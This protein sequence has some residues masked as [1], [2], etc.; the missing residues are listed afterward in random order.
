MLFPTAGLLFG[1]ICFAVG[2]TM[3]SLSRSTEPELGW[4]TSVQSSGR[5]Q[6]KSIFLLSPTVRTLFLFM[7]LV[8]GFYG[9]FNVANVALAEELGDP[10]I[11][12]IILVASAI[13]SMVMGIAFGAVHLRAPQYLQVVVTGVLLGSFYSLLVFADSPLTVFLTSTAGALFYAP[14]FISC[15]AACERSVPGNRLTEAITWLSAGNTCGTALGPT[16][17]GIVVDTMGVAASFD[18]AAAF[19][20][21]V[22]VAALASCRI[23]KRNTNRASSLA[24]VDDGS[25]CPCR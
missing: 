5:A 20:L 1:G 25:D 13:A 19:A 4:D 12:S 2:A 17:G 10:S 24:I 6:S 23:L 9:V 16:L 14:F 18:A 22:A 7:L 3:L 11:A 21:A 15:N 8:G